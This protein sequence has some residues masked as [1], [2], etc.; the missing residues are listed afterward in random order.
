[1]LNKL[2]YHAG[3]HVSHNNNNSN[4]SFRGKKDFLMSTDLRLVLGNLLLWRFTGFC[5]GSHGPCGGSH[6]ICGDFLPFR[7]DILHFCGDK[8]QF[9]GDSSRVTRNSRCS[10]SDIASNL[11]ANKKA[12]FALC[13]NRLL[14]ISLYRIAYKLLI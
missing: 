5:G 6:T 14:I 3:Q 10:T 8:P 13:K 7:G 12:I 1:M 4:P 11:P 2:T 9:P